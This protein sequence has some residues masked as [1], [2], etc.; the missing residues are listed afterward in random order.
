MSDL[1]A[2]LPRAG[3]LLATTADD[4]VVRL[5]R[6]EDGRERWAVEL[7]ADAEFVALDQ[8]GSRLLVGMPD[9]VCLLYDVRERRRVAE[10]RQHE[11]GGRRSSR[12]TDRAL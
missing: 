8:D 2:R 5:W 11:A 10:Y 7:G 3:G 6:V 4:Q 12:R 9:G 1:P